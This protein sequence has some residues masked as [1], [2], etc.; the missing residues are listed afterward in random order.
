MVRETAPIPVPSVLDSPPL[1]MPKF[2]SGVLFRFATVQ[3]PRALLSPRGRMKS[4]D[5]TRSV[6][7]ACMEVMPCLV[8][9]GAT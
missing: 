5:Q 4:A 3:F 1:G 2:K 9:Y 8:P 6:R 7:S